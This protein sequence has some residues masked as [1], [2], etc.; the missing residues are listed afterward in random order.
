MISLLFDKTF[1]Y[2]V[3]IVFA[4]VCVVIACIK[5]PQSRVYVFTFAGLILVT[6]TIWCGIQLDK[7]YTASGGI[8]GKLSG[9][10]GI[11]Q[12]E[13]VEEAKFKLKNVMLLEDEFGNYT[14][15]I[16]GSDKYN[17]DDDK[18]YNL[19][20]NGAPC[21][22]STYNLLPTGISVRC[23]YHYAFKNDDLV[24]V[25]DD[26]LKM[27]F[28]S[29]TNGYQ[30][31][32]TTTGSDNAN[33]WNKYFTKN[34]FV[35]SVE[36][37]GYSEKNEIGFIDGD[38]SNYAKVEYMVDDEIYFISA[39]AKGSKLRPISE[40]TKTGHYFIDWVDKDGKSVKEMVVTEDCILYANFEKRGEDGIFANDELVITVEDG[41]IIKFMKGNDDRTSRL[42]KLNDGTYSVGLG[43]DVYLLNLHY[44]K[45][46]GVWRGEVHQDF[47]AEITKLTFTRQ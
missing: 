10:I 7:Y 1:W 30:I 20:V 15:T 4:I 17:F 38:I 3:V 28:S 24:E 19:F 37:F 14:A 32:L 16:S 46:V 13:K 22:N 45:Q 34:N 29:F 18:T 31:K 12:S 33:Y 44:D 47:V 40:P 9:L 6:I 26:T 36:E 2:G 41:E 27:N 43:G 35:L 8:R 21:S 23:E 39:Y 11:N 25:C 5:Y 42:N